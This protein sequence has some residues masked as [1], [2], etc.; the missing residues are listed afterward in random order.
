[1]SRILVLLL[2]AVLPA[3]AQ[4]NQGN[5]K[6]DLSKKS[7]NLSELRSGG[8]PKDGIR[9]IDR[10]KFMAT[11]EAATWV[12]PKEPVLVVTRGDEARAYPL[13]ILVWNELVND[14]IGERP[15]LVSYCPLCN[16]AITF[17]R[18]V[19]GTVRDFGV[20]GML[21][22]SDMVMFDRQSDSLWQQA[23]GEAIVGAA[24]GSWLEIISSQVVSFDD[25]RKSFPRGRVLDRPT[26]DV[27]YGSTPY[28]GYEFSGRLRAPVDLKRPLPIRPTEQVVA[29]TIEGKTRAFI[30][31]Q[32]CPGKVAPSDGKS[33][34]FNVLWPVLPGNDLKSR[35][36]KWSPER[37][38]R[39]RHNEG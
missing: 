17:D 26:R 33:R 3:A 23:T 24:T 38:I 39:T 2:F 28:A 16:T 15:I 1:M 11:N 9:A 32:C 25:F 18:R 34:P 31:D 6:T 13:Q 7:I 35:G 20:S 5:W 22:N 37:S 27:R 8:P 12:G 4:L 10:P 14:R 29:V 19:D 30:F 36:R 21:R